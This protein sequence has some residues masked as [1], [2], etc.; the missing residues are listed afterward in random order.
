MSNLSKLA[1]C[2]ASLLIV[3]ACVVGVSHAPMA[4]DQPRSPA[5]T[6]DAPTAQAPSVTPPVEPSKAAA[7]QAPVAKPVLAPETL[8]PVER[9]A[10]SIESAEQ[11]IQQLNQIEGEMVRLRSDVERIIYDSTASVDTLKPQLD[12]VEKQIQRLGPPPAKDQLP[13][14][15]AVA[16][17]RARLNTAKAALDGAIKT[18]ELAWVRA[19]QL[20]DRITVMRYQLFTRNLFERR[21]SPLSPAVWQNVR[22]QLPTIYGRLQYYGGDW[23]VWAARAGRGLGVLGGAIVVVFTLLALAARAFIA[24]RSPRPETPPG[25]FERV[26]RAA[27]L[28]PVRMLAP[29]AAVAVL[30]FGLA[31]LDL[32]FSPWLSLASA[33][34]YGLLV[35]I[36]ASALLTVCLA[37]AEPAWRLVPVSDWTARRVLALL[38][39]FVAIYVVDI[40]L[41]ELGRALYVPLSVTVAQ[42]FLTSTAFAILL[43]WLVLTPFAGQT[44]P[45]R[46][47][48]ASALVVRRTGLMRPLW[49][50]LPLA[51]TAIVILVSS[52]VGYVALGR[53]IA[54]QVV[55]SGT[56]VAACGLL[57]LAVRAATRGRADNR[58]LVGMTLESRFG[59]VDPVRRR[60]FSRLI[61]LMATLVI[62]TA[63][64]PLLMLQWGFSGDDIRDWL[65]ALLF[66]LEIG[67]FRISLARILLAMALFT[68]LLF[69]T[70]LLQRWLRDTILV[71]PRVDPGIANSVDTAIG[72]AGIGLALLIALSYGGLDITSLAIVAGALSVGIGFGLQS[73]VNNFVS[74]LILLVERPVKVGDW[75]VVG[76]EQ[77]NVRKISVRSTEIETFDKAS[78]ILPNSELITGRVLNWTHR[79]PMGRAVVKVVVDPVADPEQ[80]LALLRACADEHPD[81]LKIPAPFI[82][83]DSFTGT[84]LEFTV[85]A[86]LGDVYASGR[87]ASE[88]RIAILKRLREAGIELS[89]P[90]Q[91]VHLQ[92]LSWIKTA[93]AR[94]VEGR[95]T[96]G[97]GSPTASPPG[98]QDG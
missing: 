46:P 98:D 1:K 68:G 26:S 54:H 86:V 49:I 84:S 81:T 48:N 40:V 57:Y 14:A 90:Q 18:A 56:V 28:A 53:F 63:A 2:A 71:Q 45:D 10:R 27:W 4:Q 7:S 23:L 76:N 77:G 67:Q 47:V 25:F 29:A 97:S 88:L 58:D 60:Q 44:G 32:L 15:A 3:I 31:S 6:P 30:Y 8:E 51:L 72:Y 96:G 50:K 87:V 69:A 64:L 62:A 89:N 82:T 9:L 33:T 85:R 19:K 95:S 35:Y 36:T 11:A 70:R 12:E 74:G 93:A 94:L 16:A 66:G 78:L 59:L 65:K 5:T 73:I 22:E 80:V 91:D 41:V 92:D 42:S 61:E 17:E 37:P 79:N 39:S 34:F 55:L 24:R 20:I 83:F 21:D 38:K 75:I 52:V 13:E 43:A